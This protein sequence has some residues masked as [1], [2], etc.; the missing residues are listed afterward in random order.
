MLNHT[1]SGP[2]VS[3]D[4]RRLWVKSWLHDCWHRIAQGENASYVL[5]QL[6]EGLRRAL[7]T[8]CLHVWRC[9]LSTDDFRIIANAA[10]AGFEDPCAIDADF[11]QLRSRSVV[12]YRANLSQA[13]IGFLSVPLHDLDQTSGFVTAYF[14]QAPEFS[15]L[16]LLEEFAES[17]S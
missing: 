16:Q 3:P 2:T 14:D 11:G 12:E 9:E 7:S 6:A 10:A 8:T 17:L 1:A 5:G 13:P 4:L 15:T